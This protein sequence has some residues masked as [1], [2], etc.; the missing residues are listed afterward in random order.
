MVKYEDGIKNGR[1]SDM[2]FKTARVH[3]ALFSVSLIYG[4]FYVIVKILLKSIQLPQFILLRFVLTAV[5]VLI[6][7]QLIL[8]T[9][10]PHKK[11]LLS[12]AKLGLTGVFAVQILVAIGLSLTTSFHSA[13]IM[14]TIPII[15]LILS[16]IKGQEVYHPRKLLGVIVAFIGVAVLLCSGSPK[17]PLPA[18]YLLG[19]AIVLVNAIAF[20]WFLI[21]SRS[22][23]EKYPPFSFMAYCYIISAVLFSTL[24]VTGNQIGQ[25]S[26]GLEFLSTMG[27]QQWLLMAFVVLYASIG[28][29]TLNNFALQRT[30]ASVVA[31]YIF[32]QPVISAIAAYYLLGEPFTTSMATATAI[33]FLG[34]MMT[35]TTGYLKTIPA[36]VVLEAAK[37]PANRSS[38][39]K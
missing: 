32:V 22:M 33:T 11:D 23:L 28:S 15:T 39:P 29:Y 37:T 34:V 12:I 31:L 7:D 35:T 1:E 13:L 2:N 20:S 36:D 18:H 3:A 16:I 8:K 9:P 24:Y 10:L 26:L 14:A 30:R 4:C 19:D 5:V 17:D 25:G 38:D 6:V 27:W 21:G